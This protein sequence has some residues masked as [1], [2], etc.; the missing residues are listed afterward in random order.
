M[1]YNWKNYTSMR[2]YGLNMHVI[3]I[4]FVWKYEVLCIVLSSVF[5]IW[6][7]WFASKHRFLQSAQLLLKNCF[8]D[9]T[10][11]RFW[12]FCYLWWWRCCCCC[13]CCCRFSADKAKPGVGR[14]QVR[15][16]G[17]EQCRC[18]LLVRRQPLCPRYSVWLLLFLKHDMRRLPSGWRKVNADWRE[19]NVPLHTHAVGHS[20]TRQYRHDS[21]FLNTVLYTV[22][23]SKVKVALVLQ[24]YLPPTTAQ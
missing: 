17:W 16:S 5:D 13:C 21:K 8:S 23:K 15:V 9:K 6:R 24:L 20:G 4:K 12:I 19:F 1:L 18:R 7:S 2:F 22:S 3:T 14:R 11:K 10:D